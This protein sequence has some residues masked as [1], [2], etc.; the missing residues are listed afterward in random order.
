MAVSSSS[1]KMRNVDRRSTIIKVAATIAIPM[2][3]VVSVTRIA[4]IPST[5][6]PYAIPSRQPVMVVRE[7]K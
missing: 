6:T 2:M 4:P 7:L 3:I 5:P 1:I